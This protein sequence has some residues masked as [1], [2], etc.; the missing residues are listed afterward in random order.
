MIL[1]EDVIPLLLLLM[2]VTHLKPPQSGQQSCGLHFDCPRSDRLVLSHPTRVG[3]F[4]E[5]GPA[6][7]RD[8]K[9]VKHE[10]A[11]ISSKSTLFQLF[12]SLF[13]SFCC[14]FSDIL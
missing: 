2:F 8:P 12:S 13:S 11:E 10:R 4:F 1:L 3:P 14:K 5:P 6:R 9:F 7:P